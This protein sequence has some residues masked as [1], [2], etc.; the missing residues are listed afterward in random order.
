MLKKENKNMKENL[1]VSYQFEGIGLPWR[2]FHS[3]RI[4]AIS[5]PLMTCG[6]CIAS[7]LIAF[8]VNFA[9]LDYGCS[10]TRSFKF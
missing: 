9:S 1:P 7:C 6:S 4:H 10:A 8:N 2:A 3:S 5:S